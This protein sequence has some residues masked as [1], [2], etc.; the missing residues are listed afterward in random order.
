VTAYDLHQHLWPEQLIS[1]LSRRNEPP[2]LRGRTL[3]TPEGEFEVDLSDHELQQR[4][5]LLDRDGIDVAVVSLAPTL[6]VDALPEDEARPLVEAYRDGIR[7]LADAAGGRLRALGVAEAAPGFVGAT[8][9][10]SALADLGRL[11][12]LLSDLERRG[13]VLFVHPGPGQPRPGGPAWWTSVVDYTASMQ[14]AYADWL[15]HG[16]GAYP[17][18]RVVFAILA[19]G[20][21][22]QL[23]RLR[24][25]GVEVRS[26]LHPNVFF[27]TA[28]YGRRALELCL[29]TYGVGQLVY[30]SDTPVIDPGPT[31]QS[32][33]E[34]GDAVSDAVCS[35]NPELL[36][37]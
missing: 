31:L 26:S 25:R 20:G 8:V 34:F 29:A 5:A 28:S 1:A 6:G 11:S 33:R 16:A 18:L 23:E 17:S 4:L 10:A 36:L 7:E 24:S 19:G 21:P 35:A 27:E 9:P 14:S 3:S 13:L 37:D 2:R 15:A 22:F 12:P 32:L 30:G